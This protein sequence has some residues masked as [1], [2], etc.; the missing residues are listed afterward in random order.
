M[1]WIHEV[2]REMISYYA[3]DAKRIQHFIKV[4]YFAKMIGEGE[5]LEASVQEILEIA[6]LVHDIGIRVSEEKYH[7]SAGKYQELEGPPVA[8]EMLSRIGCPVA[9]TERVCW[10]V[11]HHHTY[12]SI[13]EADHQILVE[14][15]F[16]VN[17]YEEGM[18]EPAVRSVLNKIFRTNTG[19]YLLRTLYL[20][21]TKPAENLGRSLNKG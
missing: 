1:S 9:L 3:G 7:S 16:L 6:A 4:F 14:A 8:K 17:A 19:K 21:G 20:P 12:D 11:G 13:Q 5:R 2:E 10:L 15:D 18:E